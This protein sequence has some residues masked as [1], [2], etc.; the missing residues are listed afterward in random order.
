MDIREEYHIRC[1]KQMVQL[2]EI[3]IRA[4]RTGR[5]WSD[6]FEREEKYLKQKHRVSNVMWFK[7]LSYDDQIQIAVHT[8]NEDFIKKLDDVQLAAYRIMS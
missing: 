1:T 3:N 7:N 6:E 5:A 4:D 8:S 2:T